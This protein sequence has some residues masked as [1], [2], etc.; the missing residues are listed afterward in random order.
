MKIIAKW[1]V[2]K[3][4]LEHVFFVAYDKQQQ[5]L[6]KGLKFEWFMVGSC[7]VYMDDGAYLL[8]PFLL[9]KI[10]LF[11]IYKCGSLSIEKIFSFIKDEFYQNL[12]KN[13]N[14]DYR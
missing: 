2:K 7:H 3:K 9:Y 4:L 13:L 6:I 5:Q 11:W 1:I 10:K 8:I 12:P 14:N